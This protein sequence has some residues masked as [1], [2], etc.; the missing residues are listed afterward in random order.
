MGA[1]ALQTSGTPAW[2]SRAS[3][4]TL[5][6][7]TLAACASGPRPLDAGTGGAPTSRYAGYKVG[8]P[9]QVKGVWYY[10]QDQPSYD[11]IGIASWYGEQF[12][13]RYTADGEVFDMGLPSAAHKTLPLPSLVEVTN[14]ANGRTVIVRVNDRGPFVDGR[15]IDM[16]KAAAAEL[17]FVTAGV[18][19]VRVRYVG[20]A[21]TPPDQ[22]QYQAS[23]PPQPPAPKALPA[24]VQL[25]KAPVVPLPAPQPDPPLAVAAAPAV[26]QV[27]LASL[28]SSGPPSY[29]AAPPQQQAA[30]ADVDSL[31]AGSAPAAPAAA[32]S[33]Q[34]QAGVFSSRANAEALAARLDGVGLPEVEPFARNGQTLYRVVVHGFSSPT[35]AAAARSQAAAL[36]V[37]D[38][39]VVAG[40]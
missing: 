23:N 24:P 27:P 25:A 6:A 40:S 29:A 16:S 30:L 31:L 3:L 5:A 20:R 10:P 21:P 36:G 8:K 17:G 7:L 26:S 22:R 34:V 4:L 32:V 39:R 19:K 33:F 9:Y 11:E 13:N 37:P 28:Q 38:A 15:V 14:L 18:T 1:D 2:A 12:H 35:A